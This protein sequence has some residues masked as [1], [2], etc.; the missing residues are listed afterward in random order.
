VLYCKTVKEYQTQYKKLFGFLDEAMK[1]G[2]IRQGRMSG[3]RGDETK[4]MTYIVWA[5]TPTYLAH[6]LSHVVLD[7]FQLCGIDPRQAD[8]EPFCYLLSQLL[9]DCES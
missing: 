3:M 8:G 6:E 7:L 4:P 9:L 2:Y 5:T 1:D